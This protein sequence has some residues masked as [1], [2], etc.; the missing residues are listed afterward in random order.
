MIDNNNMA[1]R[2]HQKPICVLGQ[3]A[4]RRQRG[5]KNIIWAMLLLSAE[6]HWY[7]KVEL[8]QRVSFSSLSNG[9]CSG[10]SLS[11]RKWGKEPSLIGLLEPSSHDEGVQGI[12]SAPINTWLSIYFDWYQISKGSSFDILLCRWMR[13]KFNVD[14]LAALG[15]RY[16]GIIRFRWHRY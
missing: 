12:T 8:A 7:K 9:V 1:Q 14:D 5:G 4:I 13:H 16:L 11:A 3:P 2:E 6:R 10:G 15:T